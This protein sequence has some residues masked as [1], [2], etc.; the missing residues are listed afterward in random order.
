MPNCRHN[1]QL[2]VFVT[3]QSRRPRD[4]VARTLLSE[5]SGLDLVGFQDHPYQ[6][7]P[8]QLRISVLLCDRTFD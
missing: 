6:P 8:D 7:G 3:P 5:R 1:V 2:G 4:V